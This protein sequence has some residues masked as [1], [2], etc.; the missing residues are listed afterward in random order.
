MGTDVLGGKTELKKVAYTARATA[1]AVFTVTAA[2]ER[3]YVSS[4]RI[5]A[6]DSPTPGGARIYVVAGDGSR[7]TLSC[8]RDGSGL[9][10]KEEDF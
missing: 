5:V 9:T 1:D 2:L 3:D 6:L 7:F 8:S 4:C 10:Y